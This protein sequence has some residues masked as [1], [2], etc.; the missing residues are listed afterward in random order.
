MNSNENRNAA[1]HSATNSC[2]AESIFRSGRLSSTT[3]KQSFFPKKKD[4][5]K[6]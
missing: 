1:Q 3:V 6:N 2:D 4:K 5:L